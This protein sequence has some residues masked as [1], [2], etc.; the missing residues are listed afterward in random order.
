MAPIL[1]ID[2]DGV[3][4]RYG[5]GWH[6]GT[7]YDEAVFGFFTWA[8]A[9][10]RVFRL[11][12]Y[13]S[14]S[15]SPR[16]LRAMQEWLTAQWERSPEH[17]PGAAMPMFEFADTKPP[18]FATIDDRAVRFNGNWGDRFLE[19][20][21]LRRMKTWTETATASAPS[22]RTPSVGRIV[23]L[24]HVR[25]KV[26]TLTAAVIT[27][28]HSPFEVNLQ[29]LPDGEAVYSVKNV[30]QASVPSD[31]SPRTWVWPPYPAPPGNTIGGN[32]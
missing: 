2:F 25:D 24:C 3:I 8:A 9:A 17:E 15:S 14:R 19:P 16:G 22:P 5:Q 21:R 23:L 20:N 27:K 18:A 26:E 12:I 29:V 10:Q 6:D 28:V 7:I 4:H 13:S 1:C 32:V 30:L 31:P 11:V